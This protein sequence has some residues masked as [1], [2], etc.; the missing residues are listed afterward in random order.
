M[1]DPNRNDFAVCAVII[2][3]PSESLFN[4]PRGIRFHSRFTLLILVAFCTHS[5]ATHSPLSV[6]KSH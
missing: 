5:H 6:L 4:C 3:L 2:K 1:T